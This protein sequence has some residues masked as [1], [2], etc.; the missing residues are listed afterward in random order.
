MKGEYVPPKVWTPPEDGS[1]FMGNSHTSGA[2]EKRDLPR[3]VHKLQLYSLGTPNGVKVTTFLEELLEAGV[4][5]AEYDAWL[6]NIRDGHQF[7]SGFVAVNPNSKIPA[8]LDYSNDNDTPVRVFESGAIL[9]YLA[10]KFQRFL[11]VVGDR[12]RAECLS[13][14]FFGV[15][16]APV[17]GG[18]LG[19]F[20][21][22]APTKIEYAINRNAME[23]KRLLDVMDK[24]LANNEYLCGDKITIADFVNCPWYGTLVTGT[25]YGAQKFLSV[26]EY[27]HVIRWANKIQSRPGYKRGKR[28]NSVFSS[29]GIMNRHS[30]ADFA[31]KPNE[32]GKN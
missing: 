30:A 18:G 19:H 24:H 5:E 3:G 29:D 21:N 32:T 22:Y 27:T 14:L 31:P 17:L 20:Y 6:I 23:T 11:P 16:S 4:K 7:G 26:H 25:I 9:L 13:W 15:G 1:T 12:R 28:V 2:R 8:L 10:E